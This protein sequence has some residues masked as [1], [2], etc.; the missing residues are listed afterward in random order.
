MHK[1]SSPSQLHPCLSIAMETS[2]ICFFDNL[3]T[4]QYSSQILRRWS[5]KWVPPYS[6]SYKGLIADPIETSLYHQLVVV[7]N[8]HTLFRPI[9]GSHVPV[10]SYSSFASQEYH[11]RLYPSQHNLNQDYAKAST[12]Q[13]KIISAADGSINFILLWHADH[14]NYWHFTFDI[15]FRLFY[16]I[17][18]F[19]EVINRIKL[20]VVGSS[21]LLAFQYD[22]LEAIIGRKPVIIFSY[23]SALVESALFIPPVQTLLPRTDLLTLYSNHLSSC[24]ASRWRKSYCETSNEQKDTFDLQKIYIK[25][26][27]IKNPRMLT[28]EAEVISFLAQMDFT[29]R[30]PGILSVIEQAYL[31]RSADLV[32]GPHGSAFVNMIFMKPGSSVIELTNSSYDPFHDFLLARQLNISFTRIRQNDCYLNQADESPCHRPFGID[33]N[34]VQRA[35]FLASDPSN[36]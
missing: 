6:W 1:I 29:V 15:A 12:A 5:S 33:I 13:P 23:G 27:N 14:F 26:G 22:L 24:L 9:D 2:S 34:K 17:T 20:I 4:N 31:F 11:R 36:T 19:P 16:F 30:D 18:L 3:K 7:P 10:N 25:R 32:V 21:A 8:S 35:I 28:N